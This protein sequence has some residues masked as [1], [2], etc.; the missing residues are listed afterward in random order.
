MKQDSWYMIFN[1]C[2]LYLYTFK[3]YK[4]LYIMY[5]EI[6]CQWAMTEIIYNYKYKEIQ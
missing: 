2:I 4:T 6:I 1:N 3:K 5:I